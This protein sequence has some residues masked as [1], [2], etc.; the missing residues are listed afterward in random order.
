MAA[1]LGL[2]AVQL[3]CGGQ[4]AGQVLVAGVEGRDGVLGG[5][6]ECVCAGEGG[7]R[8]T[9]GVSGCC[10]SCSMWVVNKQQAFC[11]RCQGQR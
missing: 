9:K 11:L 5:V 1:Q 2:P 7:Q 8:G 10:V 6:M 3:L 4:L